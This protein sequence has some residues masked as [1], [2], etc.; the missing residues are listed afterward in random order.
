MTDQLI[1]IKTGEFT[2]ALDFI[3]SKNTTLN[4]LINH[5]GKDKLTESEYVE[6]YYSLPKLKIES[7]YFRFG[8]SFRNELLKQ[9]YFEIDETPEPRAPYASNQDLETNWI[10]Q[11]TNDTRKFD[12]NNNPN[13]EQYGL[14]YNWGVVGVFFD[15]K[16]GTYESSL[17]YK[18]NQ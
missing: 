2:I 15:F 6:G 14:Q 3:T 17:S 5:F 18:S 1:N 12:W 11:Q 8:F 16:N 13:C 9:I 7:L 4:D 10:A